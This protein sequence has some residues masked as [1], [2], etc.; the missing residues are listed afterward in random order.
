V[1]NNTV[2]VADAAIGRWALNIQSDDVHP[3]VNTTV[4]N[5]IL[6]S[7]RGTPGAIA[8]C[9]ICQGGLVSDDNVLEDRMS[10][11]GGDSNFETVQAWR[12]A[13]GQDAHSIVLP[14]SSLGAP[15]LAALDAL[16]VGQGAANF[17][18][19]GASSALDT[20]F[21][22]ADLRIDLESRVRPAGA[23][24][25]IGA[26]EGADGLFGDAFEAASTLRWSA[27]AP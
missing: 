11:D 24:H 1:E 19:S 14:S 17:H 21:A 22:I 8:A 25:D 18:L 20:G 2:L 6:W 5:N 7:A 23:A 13:T 12:T 4:R 26:F 10:E 27:M 16:F 15:A 3:V 9:A